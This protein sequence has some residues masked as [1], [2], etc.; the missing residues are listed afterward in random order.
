MTRIAPE[1]LSCDPVGVDE[2]NRLGV[3]LL[4]LGG[5]GVEVVDRLSNRFHGRPERIGLH[6]LYV[7]SVR[8]DGYAS[9]SGP[10]RLSFSEAE[11][12][13]LASEADYAAVLQDVAAGN[14]PDFPLPITAPEARLI[15][16]DKLPRMIGFGGQPVSSYV[17]ANLGWPGWEQRV[18]KKLRAAKAVTP[19]A[20]ALTVV[21]ASLYGGTGIGHLPLFLDKLKGLEEENVAVFVALPSQAEGLLQPAQVPDAHAR[22]IAGLRGLLQPGL[23][24][25]LF[26]VGSGNRVLS[27]DPRGSAIEVIASTIAA[28]LENPAAFR[29]EQATWL[30]QDFQGATTGERLSALGAAEVVFPSEA[31][32]RQQACDHA[33]RA[34]K[35]VIE[36]ERDEVNRATADGEQFARSN[37]MT[38]QLNEISWTSPGTSAV[39]V[40]DSPQVVRNQVR[41]MYNQFSSSLPDTEPIDPRSVQSALDG[42]S[43][44]MMSR[45]LVLWVENIVRS[46][47]EHVSNS[48]AKARERNLKMFMNKVQD[49]LNQQF[50]GKNDVRLADRPQVLQYAATFMG[51]AADLLERMAR[52]IRDDLAWVRDQSEPL[53]KAREAVESTQNELPSTIQTRGWAGRSPQATDYLV[54]VEAHFDATMLDLT[55]AQLADHLD[56]LAEVCRT[57]A[58]PLTKLISEFDKHYQDCVAAAS[59]FDEYLRHFRVQPT[60]I[61]V[62]TRGPGLDALTRELARA[63]FSDEMT[64]PARA[65]LSWIVVRRESSKKNQLVYSVQYG[66][67]PTVDSASPLPV[68]AYSR[69]QRE[70]ANCTLANALAAEYAHGWVPG[71]GGHPDRALI[72]RFL[73]EKV[74]SPLLSAG[75]STVELSGAVG[76]D[77]KIIRKSVHLDQ[78]PVRKLGRVADGTAELVAD[79]MTEMLTEASVQITPGAPGRATMTTVVNRVPWNR[80]VEFGGKVM[81]N[82]RRGTLLPVH[83]DSAALEAYKIERN[84][85]AAGYLRGRD[86][87]LDPD[88]TL[89][90]RD[91]EALWGFLNLIATDRMPV[92]KPD[93]LDRSADVYHID[94]AP[95]GQRVSR[96]EWR[97]LG[98]VDDPLAALRELFHNDES[99]GLRKA[100]VETWRQASAKLVVDCGNDEQR[101][102]DMIKKALQDLVLPEGNSGQRFAADVV[103]LRRVKLDSL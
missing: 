28:W 26:L 21:I 65:L 19:G 2:L 15:L 84:A 22:G 103:L 86:R 29:S 99:P 32:A 55:L 95:P 94:L 35:M 60:L 68:L 47:T 53:R 97:D 27:Q 54:A 101:T 12:R 36:I 57:H 5:L 78:R 31:L 88:V 87:I 50:D 76:K 52:Q 93:P 82:Y 66:E 83:L 58:H 51:A 18:D 92:R 1:A 62:P 85:R 25:H 89:L 38:E 79:V 3:T 102:Q 59:A 73:D 9:P 39:A 49:W 37:S 44:T 48:L 23:Y 64:D 43:R 96:P 24:R 7:D 70:Y 61:V 4:G 13:F 80:V 56:K 67:E 8:T 42:Q 90:L 46:E 30:G 17:A 77:Q 11:S 45:H 33:A 71:Q 69:L 74:I 40:F 41:K 34:W 100:V 75:G 63:A 20:E 10:F 98:P 6:S 81:E 14:P 72:K 16:A 91:P